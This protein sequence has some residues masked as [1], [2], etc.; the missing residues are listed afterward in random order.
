MMI[1]GDLGTNQSIVNNALVEMEKTRILPRIWEKDHTVWKPVPTEITNRLDWLCIAETMKERLPVLDQLAETALN[2]GYRDVVLLGMGGS[3]LAP[4]VFSRTFTG[5]AGL[6]LTVLDSTSPGAVLANARSHDLA[7][8]LFIVATKSGGTAETLSFFKFFYNRVAETVGFEKAGDHFIAITDPS[9]KLVDIAE[10]F[11]FRATFLNDPNIGGRYSVLSHFGLVPAALIGM[12]VPLLL[13]RALEI[14]ADCGPDVPVAKNPAALL[15]TALGELAR[16]GRD[17]VTFAISSA[18]A[19]FGDWVEQLIAES[20]GKDGKGILPVVG[21]AMDT[22]EV[23]GD[24]RVFVYLRLDDDTTY[25]AKIDALEAAGHPVIRLSLRDRY[26]LGQQFFLWE[27]A[28][29]VAGERLAVNPFDQPNVEAAKILARKMIAE[30]VENGTLPQSISKPPNSQILHDF[31]AQAQPGDYIAIQAYLPPAAETDAALNALR[32]Q[33]RD[34]YRLA[35]TIG[36]GPR[37]L[38]STGQL[39]KGDAGNGLFIQFIANE[40]EDIPIPDE[41]GAPD[42]S[43]SFGVLINAQALGDWQA[44]LNARRRV[45]RFD[46]GDNIAAALANM[47]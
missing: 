31:L 29:A 3:S 10:K 39:H 38:H 5:S 43:I 4:D 27:L 46:L 33:L 6:Q 11:S 26:D 9:S 36:Y 35:T 42:S 47:V 22:P 16:N 32:I 12:D 28:T 8:T 24:D 15:G 13:D 40:P 14:V 7:Q 45:I 2:E 21:E 20:L 19:S 44:L 1:L 25:D 37:Y 34:Q 41:A 30:Y 23:Y 18:I 17:K